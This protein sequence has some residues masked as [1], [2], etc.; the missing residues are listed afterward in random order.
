MQTNSNNKKN[1][2]N[3][4]SDSLSSESVEEINTSSLGDVISNLSMTLQMLQKHRYHRIKGPIKQVQESFEE[5]IDGRRST[6]HAQSDSDIEPK[7]APITGKYNKEP[8]PRGNQEKK[9]PQI[10]GRDEEHSPNLDGC[11][12]GGKQ[13]GKQSEGAALRRRSVQAEHRFSTGAT[14]SFYPASFEDSSFEKRFER[15]MKET[16]KLFEIS[17]STPLNDPDFI[18]LGKL[19]DDD[20]IESEVYNGQHSPGQNIAQRPCAIRKKSREAPPKNEENDI[21]NLMLQKKMKL[22]ERNAGEQP[23]PNTYNSRKSSNRPLKRQALHREEMLS[24]ATCDSIVR[25]DRCGNR[26][27]QGC[28]DTLSERVKRKVWSAFCIA[29]GLEG[30]TGTQEHGQTLEIREKENVSNTGRSSTK[31]SD[32]EICLEIAKFYV[33][34]CDD[35]QQAIEVLQKGIEKGKQCDANSSKGLADLL[36]YYAQ[37]LRRVAVGSMY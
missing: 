16:G 33:E 32:A 28:L 19:D 12:N 4:F 8:L 35:V 9:P 26:L 23:E 37:L 22:G 6:P 10:F 5:G 34:K 31:K 30:D 7:S 25:I 17:S 36:D 18:N 29:P 2:I 13:S 15:N 20:S 1:N 3:H 27:G 21:F 14:T 24:D 11:T